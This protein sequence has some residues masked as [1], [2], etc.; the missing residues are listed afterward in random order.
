ME[1]L[2]FVWG[3]WRLRAFNLFLQEP[4]VRP[5][6]PVVCFAGGDKDSRCSAAVE[7]GIVTCS[8]VR[9]SKHSVDIILD[10]M[11]VRRFDSIHQDVHLVLRDLLDSSEGPLLG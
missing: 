2:D 5:R 10:G 4:F 7:V 8:L 11:E 3:Y 1:L 9:G 6:E